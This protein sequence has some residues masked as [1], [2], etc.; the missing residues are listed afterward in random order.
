MM[1]EAS[2]VQELQKEQKQMLESLEEGIVLLR[3]NEISFSNSIFD[4]IL[5]RG[6]DDIDPSKL[7]DKKVFMVYRKD[8]EDVAGSQRDVQ[9]DARS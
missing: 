8:N 9:I 2:L 1:Q 5:R 3:A 6:E 7:M 4:Q